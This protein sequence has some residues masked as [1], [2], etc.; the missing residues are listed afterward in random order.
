[1]ASTGYGITIAF[2]SGFLAEITDITLPESDRPAIDVSHTASPNKR[3][4]FIPSDLVDEGQ[5]EVE[6]NYDESEE[7]PID[8]PAEL[9]TVTFPSG[10][11]KTFMGFLTNAGAAAPLDDRMTQNVTIKVDGKITTA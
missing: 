10:T 7:P 9:V 11:V 2:A 8:D 4:Q 6:L 1:M 3:R 5:L